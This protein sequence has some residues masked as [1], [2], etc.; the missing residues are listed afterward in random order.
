MTAPFYI[1]KTKHIQSKLQEL[2]LE[3]RKYEEDKMYAEYLEGVIESAK[4]VLNIITND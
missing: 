1:E 2:K 4:R 3:I